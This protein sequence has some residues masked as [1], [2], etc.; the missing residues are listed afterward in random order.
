MLEAKMRDMVEYNI[1]VEVRE[2]NCIYFSTILEKTK[3]YY[4]QK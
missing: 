2:E 4:L 1:K 3:N